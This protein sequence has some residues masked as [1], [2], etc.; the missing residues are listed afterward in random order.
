MSSRPAHAPPATAS[1]NPR[2]CHLCWYDPS[3]LALNRQRVHFDSAHPARVPDP[4]VRAFSQSSPG[5]QPHAQRRLSDGQDRLAVPTHLL[6]ETYR[7]IPRRLSLDGREEV[8][9]AC[10]LRVPDS[11]IKLVLHPCQKSA[12]YLACARSRPCSV[13]LDSV[14]STPQWIRQPKPRGHSW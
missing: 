9:T 5:M 12:D 6:F 2:G 4:S 7:R 10:P 13:V 8:F 11:V 1:V 14:T 3:V